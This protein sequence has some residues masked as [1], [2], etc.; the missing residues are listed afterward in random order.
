MLQKYDKNLFK[1]PKV[2]HWQGVRIRS[3]TCGKPLAA[4]STLMCLCTMSYLD[5]Y[6]V[7]MCLNAQR[8]LKALSLTAFFTVGF[9]S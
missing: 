1:L 7:T 2:L 9:V 3:S 6:L 4:T 5:D 8:L